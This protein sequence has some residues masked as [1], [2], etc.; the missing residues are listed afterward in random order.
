MQSWS[1]DGSLGD[2]RSLLALAD[3]FR[4][5]AALWRDFAGLAVVFSVLLEAAV[6]PA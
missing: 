6:S 5:G 4:V 1:I 3:G 2:V